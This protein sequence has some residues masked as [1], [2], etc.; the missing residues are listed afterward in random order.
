M[1]TVAQPAPGPPGPVV[2]PVVYESTPGAASR[3]L[4]SDYEPRRPQETVLYRLVQGHLET[5]LREGRRSYPDG[6]GYPAFVENE[7]RKYLDCG[8]QSRGF[9]RVR[10][11]SCG[12]ER[13]VGFSCKGRL[14][15]SC[16]ARRAA[17]TAADLVDRLL[18]VALYR[19]WVLTFPWELRYRLGTDRSFLSLMLRTFLRTLFA[20]QRLRGRRRGLRNAETGA[21]S[22]VHRFSGSLLLFPHFHCLVPDGLFVPGPNSDAPLRFVPLPAPTDDELTE[23][24]AR[25]VGRLAAVARRQLC[26]G[27]D[28]ET[29]R[30]PDELLLSSCAA[31]ALRHP[32]GPEHAAPA[33]VHKPLTARLAGFS[34][35]AA[36]LV[37]AGDRRQLERLC[38]YG[39]RAPYAL[40][41]FS[42][43]PDG[44]VRYELPRPTADGRTELRL[45]P[46]AL[47]RRLAALLPA[48]FTHLVR[49]HGV[50][51]NRSKHRPLLPRP[52]TAESS[53]AQPL[54]DPPACS[55]TPAPEPG[56]CAPPS[57][58]CPPRP[59]RRRLPW[60]E[61]L[62]R[63]MDVD[64]LR[65][66]RC[67]AP[68]VVLAFISDPRVIGRILTHLGMPTS[69]A[70]LAPAGDDFD[71][72]PSQE[73]DDAP[74]LPPDDWDEGPQFPRDRAPPGEQ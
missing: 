10:C 34:L 7:F 70:P 6:T 16:Q 27:G 64:A 26:D 14:C 50:F 71:Q 29:A 63:V 15:P 51:A 36:R 47:L 30:D 22:F 46:V 52:P 74:D 60:A 57:S 19:Q 17:D 1:C 31:E 53:S 58:D 28:E 39:L 44:R 40:D 42:L 41:R 69:P 25:I 37:P 3:P 32:R 12:A 8:D 43:L 21:V 61:L 2:P 33:A 24:T 67:A 73:L 55:D 45:Q 11:A 5:F 65:C 18:P 49:Y 56:P 23:L 68:M 9:A 62:G 66:P 72:T 54:L 38:R 13:L 4:R 20:W 35:H 59:P 48:P